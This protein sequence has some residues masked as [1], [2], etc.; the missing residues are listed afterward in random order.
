M[1]DVPDHQLTDTWNDQD[2]REVQLNAELVHDPSQIDVVDLF[3][4][5]VHACQ[6]STVHLILFDEASASLELGALP[7]RSLTVES[8]HDVHYLRIEQFPSV[9]ACVVLRVLD[10]CNCASQFRQ[11]YVPLTEIL[12]KLL[13]L[14]FHRCRQLSD[15]IRHL[16]CLVLHLDQ[17]LAQNQVQQTRDSATYFHGIIACLHCAFFVS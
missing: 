13:N 11:L 12:L 4:R 6:E 10:G 15:L 1:G 16:G 2:E 8:L 9:R 5:V 14:G 3:R 7:R 17:D